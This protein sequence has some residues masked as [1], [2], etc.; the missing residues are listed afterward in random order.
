ME[1]K[2]SYFEKF[3]TPNFRYS[4]FLTSRSHSEMLS[5]LRKDFVTSRFTYTVRLAIVAYFLECL[6]SYIGKPIFITS[7]FRNTLL[8][9]AVGGVANS[10][11]KKML[12]VDISLGS[13][14]VSTIFLIET[15]I[16]SHS[17]F[18][19]YYEFHDSY[20]HLSFHDYFKNLL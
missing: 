14:D 8:N 15:F 1:F 11:H 16:K 3:V 12:A 10:D 2:P 9:S 13:Y 6:R 5:A 18:L 19:R 20:I 4:E 7:G 17:S